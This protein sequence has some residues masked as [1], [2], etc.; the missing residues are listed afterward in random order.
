MDRLCDTVSKKTTFL[1][2]GGSHEIRE[3]EILKDRSYDVI[4]CV[5][6]GWRPNKSAVE[7]ESVGGP[8]GDQ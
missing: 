6:R 1:V 7:G 2:I 4:T 8:P 3:G 5:V